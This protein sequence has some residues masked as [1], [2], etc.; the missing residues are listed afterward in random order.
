RLRSVEKDDT[1]VVDIRV[2]D[3]AEHPV[4]ELE[5]LAVRLLPLDK[6]QR[7]RDGT[8]GLFY[9]AVWRKSVR[10]AVN[11]GQDRA[12]AS[13]IILADAKGIGGALA[14]R[15]EAAGH[16]CHLVYRDHA[17]VQVGTRKWAVNERQPH[18]FRR[19]LEQSASSETLPCRGVVYLWGL[20]TPSIE[21]L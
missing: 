12:P 19:L 15:L 17:F 5:G 1:Q 11:S 7:P 6:V 13:W 8:D 16:H 9:R 20:D 10:G 18:E 21:G 3:A 4:A 14:S 2:Y